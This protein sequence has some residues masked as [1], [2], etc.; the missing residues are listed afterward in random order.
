MQGLDQYMGTVIDID[1]ARYRVA[2]AS[3]PT[4]RDIAPS[5]PAKGRRV[6]PDEG[7]EPLGAPRWTQF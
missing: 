6:S 1:G 3:V 5:R 7:T 4:T 2:P